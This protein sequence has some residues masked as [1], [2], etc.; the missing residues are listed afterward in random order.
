MDQKWNKRE[1]SNNRTILSSKLV[2]DDPRI[3]IYDE[4][5][6]IR[7][8]GI[9]KNS[10]NGIDQL[11]F[12]IDK[13]EHNETEKIKEFNEKSKEWNL[14]SY[15]ETKITLSINDNIDFNLFN[16]SQ[17]NE[18]E[19][20]HS[21]HLLTYDEKEVDIKTNPIEHI[22]VQIKNWNDKIEKYTR[23][24]YDEIDH[25]LLKFINEL[26]KR[27]IELVKKDKDHYGV[28]FDQHEH[29][30]IIRDKETKYIEFKIKKPYIEDKI[31][32]NSI[33]YIKCNRIWDMEKIEKWGVSLTIDKI[34][35]NN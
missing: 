12:W 31:Y 1:I 34:I 26:E 16:F 29:M 3:S 4:N 9:T 23:F 10:Y 22:E 24:Q 7:E 18:F 8:Y 33:I 5:Y 27:I 35:Q 19:R 6:E 13:N 15:V 21:R 32:E 28:N 30:S 14:G 20:F 11:Q 17:D 2:E 25:K